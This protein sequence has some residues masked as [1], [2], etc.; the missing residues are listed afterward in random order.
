[1][2]PLN[3]F[4]RIEGLEDVLLMFEVFQESPYLGPHG[5]E[6]A[7]ILLLNKIISFVEI[8]PLIVA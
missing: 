2:A 1:M 7:A 4:F 6:R 8:S 3:P 5:A